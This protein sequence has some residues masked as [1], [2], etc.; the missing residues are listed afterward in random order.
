MNGWLVDTKTLCKS[1]LAVK[2][3]VRRGG[4]AGIH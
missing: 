4:G 3:L 1:S 2:T